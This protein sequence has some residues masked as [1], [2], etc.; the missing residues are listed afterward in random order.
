MVKL[1]DYMNMKYD[2]NSPVH[3]IKS[4]RVQPAHESGRDGSFIALNLLLGTG[5]MTKHACNSKFAM[6]NLSIPLHARHNNN[7]NN[8]KWDLLSAL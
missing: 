5:I 1:V 3:L 8:N 7:N 4:V 2:Y 6:Q